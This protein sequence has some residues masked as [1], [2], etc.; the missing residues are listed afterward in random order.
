M[1]PVFFSFSFAASSLYIINDIRDVEAD[2][3]HAIK[4]NRSIARGD[5]SIA[6]ALSISSILYVSAMLI[7]AG[8]SRRFEWMIMVY[9]TIS[10]LYT[11]YLKN[12]VIA[13]IFCIA[14]GF[15]IRVLAGGEAF[16][17]VVTN[18]LFLTVFAVSLLLAS[19][20]RLGE[21]VLLGEHAQRQRRILSEYS[22]SFLEGILWFSASTA[23]VTYA[24]YTIEHNN[25]MFYTVPLA[26]FGLL[27]YI[28]VVKQGKGDPTQALIQDTFILSV[29]IIWAAMIAVIIYA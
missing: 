14:L 11:F 21:V 28:F 17:I 12:M 15:L 22:A 26:A 18:W 1:L 25:K 23:Q 20:K 7:A 4:K 16:N 27:R 10:F 24:L 2:K 19:G 13:D 6:A 5:I 3:N 8:V 29:A 9:L